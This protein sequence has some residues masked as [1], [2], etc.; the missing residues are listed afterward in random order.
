MQLD[1]TP[2]CFV[3]KQEDGTIIYHSYIGRFT[4]PADFQVVLATSEYV[5]NS[6]FRT[7]A[8]VT[9]KNGTITLQNTSGERHSGLSRFTVWE[10]HSTDPMIWTI[11]PK[12]NAE[13]A[14]VFIN[15]A[16]SNWD[17][18]VPSWGDDIALLEQRQSD[19]TTL[20]FNCLAPVDFT[21]FKLSFTPPLPLNT[22][23][24][25]QREIQILLSKESN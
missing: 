13:F 20:K 2:T 19:L 14:Q 12:K 8:Y 4:E 17:N 23:A 11:K 3:L 10:D 16:I 22:I 24:Q 6:N 25:R 5:K 7:G 1:F 9:V 21:D 15:A 18:N